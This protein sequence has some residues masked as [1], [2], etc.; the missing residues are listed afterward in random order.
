MDYKKY[1]GSSH[2]TC[3]APM[4]TQDNRQLNKHVI[5]QIIQPIV[6][7]NP[8]VSIKTLIVEIKMFMNYIS[9]YKKTWLSKQR[10][11]EMIHGN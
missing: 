9:S 7:P 5:I 8:T 10:V 2:H 4:F 3:L 6:K 1:K 11:L